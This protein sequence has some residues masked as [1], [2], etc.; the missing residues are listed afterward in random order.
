[1]MVEMVNLNWHLVEP[2]NN[3]E[4]MSSCLIV[5][6]YSDRSGDPLGSTN[7]Q[8]INHVLVG[9]GEGIELVSGFHLNLLQLSFCKLF[10]ECK[11]W[12]SIRIIYWNRQK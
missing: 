10:F 4:M 8:G 7:I 6:L 12:D 5:G 11:S 9:N 3:V 1:M 2:E